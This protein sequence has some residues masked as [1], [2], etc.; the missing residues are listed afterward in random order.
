L[1]CCELR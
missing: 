1:C